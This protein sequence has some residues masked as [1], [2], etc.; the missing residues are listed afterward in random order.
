MKAREAIELAVPS[1]P[2]KESDG[3]VAASPGKVQKGG[4]LKKDGK[5]GIGKQTDGET[6]KKAFKG[7]K[8]ESVKGAVKALS[9]KEATVKSV[10]DSLLADPED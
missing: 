4:K 8:T 7:A 5:V 6:P 1:T 10:A 3:C 2:V 9:T